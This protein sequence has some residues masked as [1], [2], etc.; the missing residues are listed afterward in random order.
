MRAIVEAVVDRGSFFEIQPLYGRAIITGLAR[1]DGWPVAVLASDPYFYGG[2]WT[3]GTP[4]KGGRV[5]GFPPTFH[6][7]PFFLVGCSGVLIRLQAGQNGA[8][9]QEGSSV[10]APLPATRP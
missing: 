5:V 9:Q 10:V 1:L 4:P 3:P 6:P 8:P 2:A 7:P